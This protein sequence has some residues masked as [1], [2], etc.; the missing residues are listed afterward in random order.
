MTKVKIAQKLTIRLRVWMFFCQ[1]S[2]LDTLSDMH[3]RTRKIDLETKSM[4]AKFDIGTKA[5]N[6]FE[7]VLNIF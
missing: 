6:F 5:C 7:N 3:G 2:I 4:R 1:I